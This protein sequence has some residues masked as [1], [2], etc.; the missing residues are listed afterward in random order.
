MFEYHDY[1]KIVSS[2]NCRVTI[3]KLGLS[4][5]TLCS[6]FIYVSMLHKCAQILKSLT[7]VLALEWWSSLEI[8]CHC[9]IFISWIEI[10]I[11]SR[12]ISRVP[13]VQIM[14]EILCFDIYYIPLNISWQTWYFFLLNHHCPMVYLWHLTNTLS[15][16][17][18]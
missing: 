7:I 9:S 6:V 16:V 13:K 8:Q 5:P 10:C 14:F 3:V 15:F 2:K 18:S 17:C 12:S 4:E 11:K 1:F